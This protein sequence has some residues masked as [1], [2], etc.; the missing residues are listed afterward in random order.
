MDRYGTTCEELGQVYL[1]GSFGY[2][3]DV[4][5]AVEVGLLPKAMALKTKAVGN[6]SLKGAIDCLLSQ[7][8]IPTC[9]Q[10]IKNT[11]EVLLAK[12]EEFQSLYLK[13]MLF[14]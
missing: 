2:Y 5:K 6:T 1:A 8:V 4:Q 11:S 12:D 3:L 13:Y 9:Q 14:E 7:D 10:I